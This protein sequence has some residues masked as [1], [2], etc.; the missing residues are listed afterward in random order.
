MGYVINFVLP[1]PMSYYTQK[2]TTYFLGIYIKKK[3]LALKKIII[4]IYETKSKI[5]SEDVLN[6]L[7]FILLINLTFYKNVS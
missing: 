3:C 1:W 5:I 6:T 4:Y 2:F 7:V